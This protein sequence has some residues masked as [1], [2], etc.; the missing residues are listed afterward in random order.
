MLK[1]YATIYVPIIAV[2]V[3]IA[4][5]TEPIKKAAGRKIRYPDSKPR[6]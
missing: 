6:P 3:L 1:R 4:A 5:A 2:N